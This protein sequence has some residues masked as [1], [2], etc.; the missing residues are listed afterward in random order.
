MSAVLDA[1]G[2]LRRAGELYASCRS[3]RDEGDQ[4]SVIVGAH[5]PGGRETFGHRFRTC[6]VRPA[7]LYF[8]Y[9][10]FWRGTDQQRASGTIWA[11]PERVEQHWS[12]QPE[13]ERT[14]TLAGAIS[15]FADATGG[16]VCSIPLLLLREHGRRAMLPDPDSAR[17][18]GESVH[19]GRCCFVIDGTRG[20]S[21]RHVTVWIDRESMLIRRCDRRVEFDA[22]SYEVSLRRLRDYAAVRPSARARA[23][24]EAKLRDLEQHSS[25]GF[26]AE[27]TTVWR[28][29]ANVHIEPSVFELRPAVQSPG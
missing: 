15:R 6:F 22:A 3:Y 19:E 18:R 11:T 12:V 26:A 24:I 14:T 17:I 5:L 21:K 9:R 28:P 1:A 27:T 4:T 7:S 25:P 13:Q 23:A 10:E 16:T 20:F 2:I 8:E 29:E